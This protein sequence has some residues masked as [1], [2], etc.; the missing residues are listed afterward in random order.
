MRR[1]LSQESKALWAVAKA[2]AFSVIIKLGFK[3]KKINEFM[4]K[5]AFSEMT[6]KMKIGNSR[7]ED[8]K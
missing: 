6:G 8:A 1:S 3:E 4:K 2:T 5:I 7:K